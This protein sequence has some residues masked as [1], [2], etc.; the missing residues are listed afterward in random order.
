MEATTDLWEIPPESATRV[1][2][3]A[4]FPVELPQRLIDLYTYEGDVVLDPFMGSG[5]TA[6]RRRAHR[7]PLRRLRHRPR[8]RRPAP[9][10]AS[11]PSAP[12]RA[13]TTVR[14]PSG[15]A[16]RRSPPIEADEAED[17]QV[18]GR[19]ARA[20]RRRSSPR[21]C[22]T[23]PG[24]PRSVADV[25]LRQARR[26]PGLRRHGPRR[27]GLGLR[28]V[29]RVQLEPRRACSA[30]TRCGSRWARPPS[31][32]RAGPTSRS[33]CSPPT[34]RSGGARATPRCTPSPA[35]GVRSSTP[36]ELLD[37]EARER[38]RSYAQ[39]GRTDR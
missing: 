29:G 7:P 28:R 10:T 36:I 18:A 24:S 26:R 2:H 39:R 30:P 23:T 1:G 6:R 20:G 19:C 32:T 38:L 16:S 12:G 27:R 14:R 33:S 35:P 13:T 31:C 5:S 3:P 34:R 37:P 17:D 8:L 21:R 22:S 15:S 4:P 11:T 9:A 25:K